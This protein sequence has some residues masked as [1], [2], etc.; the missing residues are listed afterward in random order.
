MAVDLKR[1]VTWSNEELVTWI[2]AQPRLHRLLHP[3]KRSNVSGRVFVDSLGLG[4]FYGFV[5][6]SKTRSDLLELCFDEFMDDVV[7]FRLEENGFAEQSSLHHVL[8]YLN[9]LP[10][11][12]A[13]CEIL[14]LLIHRSKIHP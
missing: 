1:F 7:K 13:D 9:L 2:R 5:K 10:T 11:S 14:K 3:V 4:F 12:L 8:T 6:S